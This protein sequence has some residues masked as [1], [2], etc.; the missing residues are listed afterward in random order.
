MGSIFSDSYRGLATGAV[1]RVHDEAITWT[2]AA[3]GT[4][5]SV[6]AIFH[7]HHELLTVD[8]SGLEVSTLHPMLDVTISALSAA[9]ARD[10][11]WTVDETATSYVVIDIRPDGFGNAKLIG[12]KVA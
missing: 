1:R 5:E 3:T 7:A 6:R 8:E 9:P 2:P 4:P 12:R 11:R 10:D